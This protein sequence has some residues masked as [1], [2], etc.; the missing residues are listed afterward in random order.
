MQIKDVTLCCIDCLNPEAAKLALKHSA[1]LC[2]FDQ[3]LFFTDTE[4][5]DPDIEII[6]TNKIS[7]SAEY[8]NFVLKEL[9]KYI[10]TS[11][12]L[13]IQ[14]DGFITNPTAWRE[15][16][17]NYDYIG[18]CWP[19]ETTI[20]QVGN[21]GF[22]LRSKRLLEALQDER[23]YTS[24][25]EDEAI[26]K[27][28]KPWLSNDYKISFAPSELARKF[29]YEREPVS[30]ETFGFH[31]LFNLHHHLD[32]S[33]LSALL[34]TLAPKNFLNPE[35]LELALALWKKNETSLVKFILKTILTSDKNREDIV[36]LLDHLI[37]NQDTE[38]TSPPSVENI[39]KSSLQIQQENPNTALKL[40]SIA[41]LLDPK[42][43]E[44]YNITGLIL[45]QYEKYKEALP[46]FSQAINLNPNIASYHMNLG[47]THIG[48]NNPNQAINCFHKSLEL[49]PNDKSV[50]QFL[51]EAYGLVGNREEQERY[52][53]EAQS[54]SALPL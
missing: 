18:A 11:H 14:W 41:T 6:P 38:N 12:V 9:N 32:T 35:M 33:T 15:E 27:D 23:A 37:S 54:V 1:Q 52:L 31:G 40:L 3:V 5:S 7:S 2:E 4:L 48:L 19:W 21:G 28:F 24:R 25:P 47:N 20:N 53:E 10:D 51:A 49:S 22:S 46:Y 39:L 50:L 44:I 16:F 26:C 43:P 17:K 30:L 36:F 45:A 8:S 29:S 13:I 42:H 34:D